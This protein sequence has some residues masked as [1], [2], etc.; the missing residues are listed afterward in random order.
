L[1]ENPV[2]CSFFSESGVGSPSCLNWG[3]IFSVSFAA[4]VWF[5]WTR[6]KQE[7]KKQSQTLEVVAT[8]K[9]WWFLL[10]DDKSLLK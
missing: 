8:I 10:D 4:F 6:Q 7:Q 3:D 2:E 1:K 9:K 5:R